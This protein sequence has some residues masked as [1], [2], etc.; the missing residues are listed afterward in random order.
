MLLQMLK[1]VFVGEMFHVKDCVEILSTRVA[2]KL[3]FSVNKSRRQ[4][5]D[6]NLDST[7]NP[8][9]HERLFD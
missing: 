7:L 8:L 2:E 6:T 1:P 9:S 4:E 5:S 3:T